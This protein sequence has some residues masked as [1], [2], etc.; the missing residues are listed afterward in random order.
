MRARKGNELNDQTAS[1]KLSSK[2]FGNIA[3]DDELENL[4]RRIA[5]PIRIKGGEGNEGKQSFD[6]FLEENC[7]QCSDNLPRL[8]EKWNKAFKI[9]DPSRDAGAI[10]GQGGPTG[11]EGH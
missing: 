5:A 7:M 6:Q 10:A 4:H 1:A 8:N 11:T 9:S 3:I 2:N